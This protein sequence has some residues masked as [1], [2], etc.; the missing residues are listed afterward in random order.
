MGLPDLYATS[1]TSSFTPGSW[2]ALDYGPYNN[3]GCT[4][5]LYGAFERYALGWLKPREINSAVSATLQPI[6]ENVCGV[7][8]SSKD[9][10]FFLVENRQKEGWDAYIPGHGMLVWHVDYNSSVWSSNKVNN[11]PSH[12]YCDIEEA[13]GTQSE[14]SRAGDAFPGT[15]NKTSFTSSTTPAMKTWA[16]VGLEYPLTNIREEN[17]NIYFDIL[18]G[19]SSEIPVPVVNEPSDITPDSFKLSWE[20][21]DGY[22]CILTVY[23]INEEPTDGM[24]KVA[25]EDYLPGFKNRNMGSAT[26]VVISGLDEEQLYGYTVAYSTGW[27]TSN[28]A[29]NISHSPDAAHSTIT[30]LSFLTPTM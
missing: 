2:S 28:P 23:K 5:P 19:G 30:R 22:D 27:E 21:K 10:E 6:S 12:Q 4:P 13:D 25:A 24:M 26:E 29:R 8:R 14:S 20:G 7:I 1:Y 11:T 3:N 15:A 16:N 18:G 17:G 9:T